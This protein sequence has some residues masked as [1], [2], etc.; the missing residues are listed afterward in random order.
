MCKKLIVHFLIIAP[1]F[2]SKSGKLNFQ[3]KARYNVE[4][5]HKEVKISF[6][7][8]QN[9]NHEDNFCQQKVKGINLIINATKK[10]IVHP[11]IK[12]VDAPNLHL[13]LN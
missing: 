6:L 9:F 13:Q 4:Q 8:H 11:T 3:K 7:H 12:I 10:P 2:K 1:V 5:K